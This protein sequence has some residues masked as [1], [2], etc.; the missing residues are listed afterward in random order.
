MRQEIH[1]PFRYCRS[2][3]FFTRKANTLSMHV[4]LKHST[5][6][7]H[8]CPICPAA[9]PT[10]AQ[11]VQHLPKH[12]TGSIKCLDLNCKLL[13]KTS[14]THRTHHIRCHMDKELLYT[15]L[16]YSSDKCKCLTCGDLFSNNA[17]IYHVSGCSPLSPF[18]KNKVA[19]IVP[20]ENDHKCL[21][22]PGAFPSPA[23][24]AHHVVAEHPKPKLNC[25]V[26]WYPRPRSHRRNT[27]FGNIWTKNNSFGRTGKKERFVFPAMASTPRQI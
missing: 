26:T 2:C 17:I 14:T 12:T 19:A 1:G 8:T 3:D 18:S 11:L 6:N 5:E 9:F 22:C 15:K 23:Q 21:L 25:D 20:I 16:L 4:S 10:R 27:T 7:N 24:L 13:F